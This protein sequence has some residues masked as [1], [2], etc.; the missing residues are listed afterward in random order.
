MLD[1]AVAYMA[2][3][4]RLYPFDPVVEEEGA[5]ERDGDHAADGNGGPITHDNHK[6]A[7]RVPHSAP[8]GQ[9][10]RLP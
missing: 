10:R 9:R 3:M 7:T 5:V 4:E 6:I 2:W 8:G 1:A